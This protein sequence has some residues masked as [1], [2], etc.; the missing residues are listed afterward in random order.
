MLELPDEEFKIT[1]FN[2]IKNGKVDN[3]MDNVSIE[4]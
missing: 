1:M 2:I 3:Q 4:K